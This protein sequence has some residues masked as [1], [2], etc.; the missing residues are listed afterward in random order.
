M[1]SDAQGITSRDTSSRAPTSQ[2]T[3]SQGGAIQHGQASQAPA[4]KPGM[5][6]ESYSG[7]HVEGDVK[8]A[9]HNEQFSANN[10][11]FQRARSLL[12]KASK[13]SA[14]ADAYT[15]QAYEK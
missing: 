15:K 2:T 7:K 6:K 4:A 10:A 1:A 13:E 3:S 11:E 8:E 12:D 9:G 5:N 14:Q